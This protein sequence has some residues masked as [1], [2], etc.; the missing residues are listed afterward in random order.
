LHGPKDWSTAQAIWDLY[1]NGEGKMTD[2]ESLKS[3]EQFF[4][5]AIESNPTNAR[6]DPALHHSR[7]CWILFEMT[8]LYPQSMR[9]L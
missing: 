1:G 9:I 6:W 7:H 5:S 2:K 8:C 3:A 4:L